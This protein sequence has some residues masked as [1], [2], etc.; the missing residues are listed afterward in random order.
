MQID[1]SSKK[2]CEWQSSTW[3]DAEH[4]Q[5]PGKCKLK[6]Q[7]DT[8]AYLLEWLRLKTNH[9]KSGGTGTL[10]HSRKECKKV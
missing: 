1:I 2:V 10:I 4:Y 7:W 3:K 9:K 8:T 6:G 5:S